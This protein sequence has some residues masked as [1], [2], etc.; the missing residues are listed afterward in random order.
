MDGTILGQGTFTSSYFGVNPNP[1]V[2]SNQAASSTII[3]IP[4]GAD[5]LRV[6]N[7]TKYAANGL[8]SVYFQGTANAYAGIEY[9]WQRGMAPGTGLVNYKTNAASTLN[10]DALATGGFTLY[11]PSG[12]TPGAQPLLSGPVAT[13]AS[14]NATQPVVTTASTAGISVGTIVRM[15]NTAQTDVN[16]IDMV[17]GAV[18]LNTSFT[19]LTATNALA[20]VPGAIGGAGFYRIVNYNS[21]FYPRRRYITNITQ[22]VTPTVSLSVPHGMVAGQLVRFEIPTRLVPNTGMIQLD[23]VSATILSVTDDYNVVVSVDTSAMTAFAW[24]TIAQQPSSFP[25]LTMYG[26][27]TANALTNVNP[28]V[29]SIAGQQIFNTQTGILSDAVVNVGYLGMIL[30]GGGN[31]VALTTPIAGPAGTVHFAAT[32]LIDA[33]DVI[34]WVAGK[35][36]YGGQ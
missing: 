16:G 6:Y 19:L 23:G 1:G 29:P 17:V 11:D 20:N 7:Y 35:S 8:N 26:E 18:T 10:S 31:G 36:S 12:N 15:S 9:Y 25:S 27:D 5:W 33:R 3:A 2:A 22:A 34:Y 28:Q 32:N 21:L 4:S 24:P 30:G 14:T 13:T